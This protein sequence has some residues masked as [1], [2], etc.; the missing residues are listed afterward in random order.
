MR[1]ALYPFSLAPT[2]RDGAPNAGARYRWHAADQRFEEKAA[3]QKFIE[4]L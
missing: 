3:L 2:Q 4:I 1:T